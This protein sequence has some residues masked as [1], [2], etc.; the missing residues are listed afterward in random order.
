MQELYSEW[1]KSGQESQV[2]WLSAKHNR[3]SNVGELKMIT[4]YKAHSGIPVPQNCARVQRTLKTEILGNW[5]SQQNQNLCHKS[6]ES[7]TSN[8]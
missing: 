7:G 5:W 4:N 2:F 3:I 1:P 8:T 6:T